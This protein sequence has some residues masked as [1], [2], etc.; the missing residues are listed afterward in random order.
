MNNGAMMIPSFGIGQ[1]VPRKEDHGLLR[2]QGRYTADVDIHHQ[3]H[4]VMVRSPYAH[5]HIRGI[6]AAVCA[7]MPGVRAI[8]TAADL[9][10]YGAITAGGQAVS[11]RDGTPFQPPPRL[12]LPQDRVRYV[13]E[14]IACVVAETRW[15]AKD[16]AEAVVVDIEQL[17]AVTDCAAAVAPGAVQLHDSCP[18]N[19]VIDFQFGDSAVVATAFGKAAHVVKQRILSNRVVVNPMET[20]AAVAI[21]DPAA[22]HWTLHTPSQGVFGM[23]QSLARVLKTP[24]ETIRVLT[25]NVGGSF[26]MKGQIYPE[27][28]CILHAARALGRPVKWTDDRSESFLSDNHGRGADMTAELALDADGRFLAVRLTGLSDLGA[29]M[30]AP[31]IGTTNAVKNLIG[32]YRTALIEVATK[33]VLTNT[34]P[35]GAYRGAG[36]PEANY[37]MGRLIDLAAHEL[38]IDGV[39]LRRRNLIPGESIPYQTPSKLTYDSGDFGAVLSETLALAD[40]DN[41]AERKRHSATNGRLRGLGVSSYLE[42]TGPAGQ[43]MGGIRFEDDGSITMITGTLDYGQGHASPFAQLLVDRLGVPF[44]S[45]C[46]VQGDSDQL[47][48]GGGSGGSKSMMASGEALLQACAEVIARGKQIASHMLEAAAVDIEFADGHFSV[49]GTDRQ[50]ALTDIAARIH[51]G[52]ALPQDLPQTLDA[53]LSIT[54]PPSS[55]PNGCHV[56]EVEVDPE[57]GVVQVVAY[58]MIN[59]FGVVI[60]PLIVEGQVH[61]GV[62]QGIGQALL[63]RTLYDAQGQPVTGSFMDYAMPRAVDGPPM[64]LGFRPAPAATNSLGV[65]GCGEAGCAGSLPAVMGAVVDALSIYGI[66]HID[67]PC[68]PERV[69]RAIQAAQAA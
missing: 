36:R 69:W 62:M 22:G 15:Q 55:Y 56:A 14:V 37:Y 26:G 64:A 39:E 65:K 68:T 30:A 40:W 52:L 58:A 7:T 27:Q 19:V 11:N 48:S 2:G 45:I 35:V 28:I 61:G 8:Y 41:F 31:Q 18:G 12:A 4:A 47:I 17:P 44:D 34:T 23:R 16:A 1:R 6:N 49:A 54:T 43:E 38:G 24:P 25:G 50:L 21:H 5:G 66:R 67:M 10:S 46:L 20:R 42:S 51:A 59:D 63:E 60:N 32:T 13:G 9:A 29:F 53:S 57:T 3:L 33:A